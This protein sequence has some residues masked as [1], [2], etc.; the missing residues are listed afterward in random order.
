MEYDLNLN[1]EEINCF[2]TET[3]SSKCGYVARRGPLP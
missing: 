2:E 3:D 1:W